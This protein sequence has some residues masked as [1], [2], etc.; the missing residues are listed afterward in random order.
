MNKFLVFSG[1]KEYYEIS[2]D[3]EKITQDFY[4]KKDKEIDCTVAVTNHIILTIFCNNKYHS[5][6]LSFKSLSYAFLL[7]EEKIEYLFNLYPLAKLFD[8]YNLERLTLYSYSNNPYILDKDQ[9]VCLFILFKR[10]K[11]PKCLYMNFIL[12]GFYY[13]VPHG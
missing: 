11:T 6:R 1:N 4:R 7:N 13:M 9:V 3:Y 2:K 5:A 12:R 10:F 8:Y